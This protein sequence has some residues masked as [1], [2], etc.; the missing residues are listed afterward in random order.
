[1]K[2][3]DFEKNNEVHEY[4]F[5][6]FLRFMPSFMVIGPFGGEGGGGSEAL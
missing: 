6:Q 5:A 4:L 2:Y 1:M 3:A